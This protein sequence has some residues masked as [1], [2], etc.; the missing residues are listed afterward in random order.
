M[1]TVRLSAL[2]A[3]VLCLGGCAEYAYRANELVG[4]NCRPEALQNGQCVSTK[5]ARK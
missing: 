5:G 1:K 4:I 2:L 3:L